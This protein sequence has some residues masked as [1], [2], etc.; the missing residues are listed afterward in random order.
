MYSNDKE[1]RTKDVKKKGE[2]KELATM[3]EQRKRREILALKKKRHKSQHDKKKW[4]NIK[5][6]W[7]TTPFFFFLSTLKPV[8]F[9]LELNG[10]GGPTLE[11][12]DSPTLINSSQTNEYI[13]R[14]RRRK[15]RRRRSREILEDESFRVVEWEE[16]RRSRDTFET[17]R[18]RWDEQKG[19]WI[20]GEIFPV[21]I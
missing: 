16:S 15:R 5:I 8:N 7:N 20:S 21:T 4:N 9:R 3:K 1:G 17:R 11:G 18:T 19:W 14:G 12:I 13:R 2:E 10:R 6:D